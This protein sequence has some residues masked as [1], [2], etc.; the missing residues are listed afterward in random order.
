MYFRRAGNDSLVTCGRV[1]AARGASYTASS[2]L[3][4]LSAGTP[5]RTLYRGTVAGGSTRCGGNTVNDPAAPRSGRSPL[6]LELE[7]VDKTGVA[8]VGGG[9]NDEIAIRVAGR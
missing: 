4:F 1:Q 9:Q 3:R 5:G 8:Q 7:V 6:S 2:P